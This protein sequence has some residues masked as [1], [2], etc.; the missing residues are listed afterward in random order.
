MLSH[1][2]EAVKGLSIIRAFG[3]QVTVPWPLGFFKFG[4]LCWCGVV[5]CVREFVC[6][7]VTG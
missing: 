6:V 7:D 1:Y 5:P 3:A 2:R 4:V